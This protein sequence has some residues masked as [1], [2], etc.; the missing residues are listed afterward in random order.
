VPEFDDA[1]F[2]ALAHKIE[3]QSTLRRAWP[4]HGGVSAQV[5]ALELARPDG[6]TQRLVVRRYGAADLRNNPRVAADEF[7][8]LAYLHTAGL[9]VP[10]PYYADESGTLFP[11]PYLVIEFMEGATDLAPADLPAYLRRLTTS[12]AQ[13]HTLAEAPRDLAFLPRQADWLTAKLR[14]RPVV[15]DESLDEGRI[16]A[17]LEAG[18]PR[19]ARNPL[20]LVHGDFWPGNILWQG[21][22]LAAIL[23]WETAC[24]GDPLADLGNARLEILFFFGP[25]AMQAFTEQYLALTAW[26]TTDLSYWDLVAALR[27]AGQL[28][29]WG[30]DPAL[31]QTMR[32]RHKWFIA[33]AFALS[34]P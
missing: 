10:R 26:D 18:W 29:T 30:L 5:T 31:E 33:Q 6:S 27:V 12:L 32:A 13:I 11:T 3:P 15:L 8:L 9:L 17:A 16:R 2:S 19:V 28:G 25:E 34:R 21:D 7:R 4:L 1:P 24:L 20:V 23:D 14:R 22:R